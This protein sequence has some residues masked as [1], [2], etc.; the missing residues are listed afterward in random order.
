MDVKYLVRTSIKNYP[1]E[2]F[3]FRGIQLKKLMFSH[4]QV[5]SDEIIKEFEV[6]VKQA[7]SQGVNVAVQGVSGRTRAPL[8]VACVLCERGKNVNDAIADIKQ[9]ISG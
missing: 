5:P 1:E 3:A 6:I 4:N 8:L 7:I 2:V 9:C